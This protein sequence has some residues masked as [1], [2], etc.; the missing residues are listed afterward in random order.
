M[1][2]LNTLLFTG[3]TLATT[4]YACSAPEGPKQRGGSGSLARP[5]L[6]SIGPSAA[7]AG[8]GSNRSAEPPVGGPVIK[9]SPPPLDSQGKVCA[10]AT[11]QTTK[12]PPTVYFVIDGS[13]S[14]C[15]DFGGSTRW[16]ALRST[17]LEPNVGL[18]HRL[19]GSVKFGLTLYDGTVNQ[20]LSMLTLAMGG[21]GTPPC[22]IAASRAKMFGECPGLVESPPPELN[23]AGVI[24]MLYPQQELGGSTPTDRAIGP[25]M[26]RLI[27]MVGMPSP[28]GQPV[29]DI[30]VILATDGAPND[31]CVGGVGGDGSPQRQAVV[32]AADRGA[33]AGITTYVISLAGDDVA[34]QAHLDEVAKH[35]DPTN[36]AAKTLVPNNPDELTM[37]LAQLLGGAIGCNI[38]LSGTV[39][40]GKECQGSVQQNGAALP[41]CQQAPTGEWTCDNAP[42]GAP[43]GWRLADAHSI[44]LV[45]QSCVDFL[46]GSGD[47]L[48]ATFPCDVFIPD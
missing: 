32:A 31:I 24:D 26:D 46:V 30:Y 29:G 15:A 13:G 42:T 36:P 8:S 5:T 38:A 33:A 40:I 3:L 37:T 43:N 9:A 45:G 4:L 34:L 27:P 25:V 1:R 14:M 16:Q 48:A 47:V 22:A 21:G 41:C 18:I 12:N 23:N 7:A 44:E 11:V 35:G 2:I 17:L 10:S 39:S 28:D 6:G 20:A 19:Q